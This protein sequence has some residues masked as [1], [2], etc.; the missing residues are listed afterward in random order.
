MTDEKRAEK[1]KIF[2][3]AQGLRL[4]NDLAIVNQ[5]LEKNRPSVASST[6]GF[7]KSL[8]TSAGNE[9]KASKTQTLLEK[10][11]AI[12]KEY[13]RFKQNNPYIN[14]EDNP[15]CFYNAIEETFDDDP[16]DLERTLFSISIIFDEEYHYEYLDNGLHFISEHLWEQENFLISIK[17]SIGA[18]YKDLAK[19]PLS[20]TQK[21]ILG[22]ASA[23]VLFTT[24]VPALAI[25]GLAADG[26]TTGLAGFGTALGLGGTMV[27]GVGLMAITEAL[28]DGALIGFTYA[29]LDARNK[30]AVQKSFREMNFNSVAQML[31]IKCYI[32]HAAKQTM[33]ANLFKE[34]TNE[35]LQMITD[36]KSDTD[37]VLLVEHQN[38]EENKKKI[39]VF[40][41][42][43]LKLTKILC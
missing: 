24:A 3:I 38:V 32:M 31:A 21:F 37:Y 14:C 27:E 22:G 16:Y 26:I 15:Y 18:I 1:A 13:A 9:F 39:Q 6:D 17:N 28:L 8:F 11:A 4:L 25:G 12:E 30:I 7:F 29:F 10:K 42:L 5:E 34:K 35:L 33:P 41:N 2:K 23:L 40:H 19:Q 43:D 20:T 36:L